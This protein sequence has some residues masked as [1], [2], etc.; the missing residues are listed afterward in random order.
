MLHI[1]FL[2]RNF[3]L[4]FPIAWI[5]S[6]RAYKLNIYKIY[7]RTNYSEYTICNLQKLQFARKGWTP[8]ICESLDQI[9]HSRKR[10]ESITNYISH[11]TVCLSLL[12]FNNNPYLHFFTDS[13]SIA[14][15]TKS[16]PWSARR[17]TRQSNSR[18]RGVLHSEKDAL[19]PVSF[20]VFAK[21]RAAHIALG[22]R[23][24]DTDTPETIRNRHIF[25]LNV[26]ISTSPH[27]TNTRHDGLSRTERGTTLTTEAGRARPKTPEDRPSRARV[28]HVRRLM[29]ARLGRRTWYICITCVLSMYRYFSDALSISFVRRW[30]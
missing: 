26:R 3:M 10:T 25:P 30:F 13:K 5:Y 12:Q 29:T 27:A 8:A 17:D 4:R 7:F 6:L 11:H 14:W 23:F 16:V 9:S 24:P 28:Y 1:S 2:T 21:K 22:A 19:F 15:Y 18:I 20:F